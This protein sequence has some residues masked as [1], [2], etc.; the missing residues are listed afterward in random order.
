MTLSSITR[1]EPFYGLVAGM[2]PPSP[3]SF[4]ATVSNLV[5]L[6]LGDCSAG[7]VNIFRVMNVCF[8]E[9]IFADFIMPS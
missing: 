1:S 9:K 4:T 3:E 8:C 2:Q 5:L 6:F 7:L